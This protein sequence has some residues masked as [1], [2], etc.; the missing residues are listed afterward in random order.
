VVGLLDGCL[1]KVQEKGRTGKIAYATEPKALVKVAG[2]AIL[3][4]SGARI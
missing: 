1:L 4:G 3:V 2:F